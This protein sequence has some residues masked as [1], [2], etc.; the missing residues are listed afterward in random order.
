LETR[1]LGDKMKEK[2]RMGDEEKTKI[3]KKRDRMKNNI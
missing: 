3:E 1:R 2:G